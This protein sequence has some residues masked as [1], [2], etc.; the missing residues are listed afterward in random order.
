MCTN[1]PTVLTTFLEKVHPSSAA[2]FLYYVWVL[3]G[4]P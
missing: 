1:T 3:E 2:L 4:S